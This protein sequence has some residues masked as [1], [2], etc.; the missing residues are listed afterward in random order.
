M[1]G[2]DGFITGL[3]ETMVPSIAT[4][5]SPGWV[6]NEI[7]ATMYRSARLSLHAHVCA[8]T[9]RRRGTSAWVRQRTCDHLKT[10]PLLML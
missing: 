5:S 7:Q 1:H 8:R 4:H 2:G 9:W 10:S 6:I 3:R